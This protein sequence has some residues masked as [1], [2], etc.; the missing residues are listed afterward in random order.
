MSGVLGVLL[1]DVLAEHPG[2]LTFIASIGRLASGHK[3]SYTSCRRL[4]SC[5]RGSTYTRAHYNFKDPRVCIS[6]FKGK[7]LWKND[8]SSTNGNARTSLCQNTW[9][10]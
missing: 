9:P 5:L 6:G 4:S 1:L 2:S 10:K 3:L 8:Q 7:A